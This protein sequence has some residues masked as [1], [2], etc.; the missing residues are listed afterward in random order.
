MGERKEKRFVYKD[1]VLMDTDQES[2]VARHAQYRAQLDSQS[3]AIRGN[4][5]ENLNRLIV[6]EGG[7]PAHKDHTFDETRAGTTRNYMTEE[8]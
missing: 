5:R 3:E 2:Y 4:A 1:L 6:D 7:A 8:E